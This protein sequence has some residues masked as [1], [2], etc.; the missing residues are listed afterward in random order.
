[1]TP[2]SVFSLFLQHML[3]TGG[4][5]S[6]LVRLFHHTTFIISLFIVYI[7]KDLLALVP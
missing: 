7:V 6:H 5:Y 4:S 3:L 2:I 1:M